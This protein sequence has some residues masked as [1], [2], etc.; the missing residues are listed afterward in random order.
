MNTAQIFSYLSLF[1]VVTELFRA[2]FVKNVYAIPT[3][4]RDIRVNGLKRNQIKYSVALPNRLAGSVWAKRVLKKNGT[5]Y[6]IK[7]SKP[8]YIFK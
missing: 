8:L 1:L 6:L 7:S 4:M 5:F 3:T 2:G